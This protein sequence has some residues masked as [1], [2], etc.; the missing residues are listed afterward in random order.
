MAA[1]RKRHFAYRRYKG[2]GEMKSRGSSGRPRATINARSA[3]A[4]QIKERDEAS[5]VF[6]ELMGNWFEPTSAT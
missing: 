4:G 5:N 6:A 3:H 1:G 2:L